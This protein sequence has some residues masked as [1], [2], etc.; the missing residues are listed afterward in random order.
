MEYTVYQYW[1]LAINI[2][3]M[4]TIYRITTIMVVSSMS[5]T[6]ASFGT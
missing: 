5:V 2:P 1:M 3:S 6:P 4:I